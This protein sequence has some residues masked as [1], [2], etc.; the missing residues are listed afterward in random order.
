MHVFDDVG[1]IVSKT[2]R[3]FDRIFLFVVT[4]LSCKK[5]EEANCDT[6]EFVAA[7]GTSANTAI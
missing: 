3:I 2:D 4:N 1:T 6:F 5:C 7:A